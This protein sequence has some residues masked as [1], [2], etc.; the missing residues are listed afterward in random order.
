MYAQVQK[1]L[2]WKIRANILQV[3]SKVNKKTLFIK[4][5]YIKIKS[6]NEKMIKREIVEGILRFPKSQRSPS[7]DKNWE[8][9]ELHKLGNV[10][11]MHEISIEQ[12][13][14]FGLLGLSFGIQMCS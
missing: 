6:P 2:I 12:I 11:E 8:S 5:T 13:C 3:I 7:K 1:C 4:A 9:Y 10:W 14:D